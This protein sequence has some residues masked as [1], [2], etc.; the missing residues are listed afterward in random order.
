MKSRKQQVKKLFLRIVQNRLSTSRFHLAPYL[1]SLRSGRRYHR[2]LYN[3]YHPDK[4]LRLTHEEVIGLRF[5][6]SALEEDWSD[7][8]MDG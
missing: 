1:I 3:P 2:P 4:L 7:P 8:F 5:L 6:F